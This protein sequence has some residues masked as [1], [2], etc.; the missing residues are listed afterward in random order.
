MDFLHGNFECGDF[1][2]RFSSYFRVRHAQSYSRN[3]T[4][5]TA[6]VEYTVTARKHTNTRPT[7]YVRT[8]K[9]ALRT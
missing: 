3:Y 2:L 5:T 8:I 4:S 9:P 7:Q 1:F 6:T